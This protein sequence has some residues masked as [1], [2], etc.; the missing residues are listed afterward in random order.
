ML[1]Q[2]KSDSGS[3]LQTQ[4]FSR[5]LCTSLFMIVLFNGC[6]H[7]TS[8]QLVEKG[9]DESNSSTKAIK[10]YSQAIRK[11]SNNVEAYWRRADVYFRRTQY[12]KSISDLNKA[13]LLDSAFNVGYLFG[14]RGQVHEE[15]GDF[16]GAIRDYQ[17]IYHFTTGEKP[18]RPGK[19][20][21]SPRRCETQ[22]TMHV[23]P[24]MITSQCADEICRGRPILIT[25]QYLARRVSSPWKLT[26]PQTVSLAFN[27][28]A[29]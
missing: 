12:D 27:V 17:L 2:T 23:R 4:T 16:S 5:V 29:N 18:A 3:S 11:D 1:P 28:H 21:R 10:W 19:S 24:A 15:I 14:D 26:R 8:V 7:Y 20:P 6:T 9:F 22:S 13:I 25:A